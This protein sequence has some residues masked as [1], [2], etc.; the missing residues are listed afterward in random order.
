MISL[1]VKIAFAIILV[2]GIGTFIYEIFIKRIIDLI[3][4]KKENDNF[5]HTLDRGDNDEK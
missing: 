4:S 5:W 3:K 1:I 2:L